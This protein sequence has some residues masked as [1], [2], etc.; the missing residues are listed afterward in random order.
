MQDPQVDLAVDSF[1]EQAGNQGVDADMGLYASG[2]TPSA[3]LFWV[4]G[5]D[6]TTTQ[7]A[8][9]EFSSGFNSGYASGSLDSTAKTSTEV[10]GV[11][12]DCAPLVGTPSGGV[13]MWQEDEVYWILFDMSGGSIDASQ[14]LAVAAHEAVN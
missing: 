5:S 11:R 2:G 8:W 1:R 3:G 7:D 12:Y 10:A 13:C 9:S 6:V 4:D 14:G